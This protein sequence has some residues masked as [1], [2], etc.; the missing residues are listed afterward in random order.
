MIIHNRTLATC[1][2]VFM[3]LAL[4]GA[5]CGPSKSPTTPAATA[6]PT[7]SPTAP[8]TRWSEYRSA[9][10]GIVIPYPEGWYVEERGNNISFHASPPPSIATEYPAEMWFERGE[11]TLAEALGKL[12]VISQEQVVRS[13][14]PMKRV[15]FREDFYDPPEVT[16]YLWERDG[17]LYELGGPDVSVVDRAVASLEQER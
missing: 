10:I 14:V 1:V 13:G 4:L 5:G 2:S 3:A 9:D 17:T 11:R 8:I 15:I 12:D 16:L 6:T 7:A